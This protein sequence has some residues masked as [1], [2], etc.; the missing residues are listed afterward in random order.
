MT[1]NKWKVDFIH[2]AI[3]SSVVKTEK[4]LQSTSQSQ[5]CTK[6]RSWS[7]FGG[8]QPVWST[9]AFWIPAKPL[10]LSSMLSKLM[11]CTEN[12]NTC[13]QHWSTERAQFFSMTTYD[14]TWHDQCFKSWMNWATKFCLLCHIHLPSH[15]STTLLQ[16]SIQP[17]AGKMLLHP[18]G[19]RKCFTRDYQI[20]K[21]WFLRYRNKWTYFSLAKMCWL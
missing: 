9:T 13:S 12:C 5:T 6:T 11:R 7:L 1:W 8:R 14:H 2:W 10:N 19:G 4:E 18:A 17:F 20:P 16:A 15:Q 21:H 3:T